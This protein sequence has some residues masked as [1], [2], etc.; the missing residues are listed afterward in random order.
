[1][2]KRA[3]HGSAAGKA[4]ATTMCASAAAS[5]AAARGLTN[6]QSRHK[7]KL[8]WLGLTPSVLQAKHWWQFDVHSRCVALQSLS[9]TVALCGSH[10][11][12]LQPTT[13]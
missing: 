6:V 8:W 4:V 3:M 12:T 5:G 1:M 11:G 2:R 7:V 10:A 9:L 13:A